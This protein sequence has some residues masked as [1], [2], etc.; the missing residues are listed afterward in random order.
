MPSQIRK[1]KL[2][3]CLVGERAVGKT[4]L[5]H[6]YV[7][8]TFDDAYRGTLGS[9]LY[10]LSFSKHVAA[11]Q[12][13]EAQV[14]LFDLMGEHAPRDAFRDAMFWGAHGFLAVA[15]LS[16]SPT[17]YA[18]PQWVEAVR[19]VA[20]DL[21]Y[22]ILLNKADLMP[23][24][25][26]GPQET[27]WLLGTFPNIPYTTTS[28]KTG[29]GVGRAFQGLLERVVDRILQKARARQQINALASRILGF[30]HKRGATGVTKNELLASFKG[31]DYQGLMA[32]IDALE[33][34]GYVVQEEIGPANF[35]VLL[36]PQGEAAAVK[37]GGSEFVIEEPT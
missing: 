34:L 11:D 4:S 16:R 35:R 5:L 20:G 10:L 17:L 37:E 21:P 29:E 30:A 31:T 2:K 14:A 24:G 36:T 25:A 32:E 1:M 13:V 8:N 23:H 12:V 19:S 3:I 22:T 6:R 7:F 18:I 9:K 27:K 26:I 15:D 28:A 33:R